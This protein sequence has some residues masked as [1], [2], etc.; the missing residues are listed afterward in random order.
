MM[1]YVHIYRISL[2]RLLLG[3]YGNYRT[4]NKPIWAG[5]Q[6]VYDME[7]KKKT[8]R[9]QADCV[10]HVLYAMCYTLPRT[11]NI[12]LYSTANI[13]YIQLQIPFMVCSFF[14]DQLTRNLR[15]THNQSAVFP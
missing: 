14:K 9:Y 3:R 4:N 11:V 12:F 6:M 13:F 10:I 15:D 2:L 5:H 8:N 7:N 1:K